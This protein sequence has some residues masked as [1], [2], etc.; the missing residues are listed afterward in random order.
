MKW[1]YKHPAE[2]LLI[3][4]RE[5]EDVVIWEWWH[6]RDVG[7]EWRSYVETSCLGRN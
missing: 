7:R 5:L 3:A 2:V 4:A 6:G 1:R